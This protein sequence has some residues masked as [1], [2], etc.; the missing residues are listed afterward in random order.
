VSSLNFFV[1]TEHKEDNKAVGDIHIVK[2]FPSQKQAREHLS[3]LIERNEKLGHTYDHVTGDIYRVTTPKRVYTIKIVDWQYMF[4]KRVFVTSSMF[5]RIGYNTKLA[6]L[7]LR[8][9]T[10]NSL[11]SYDCPPAMFKALLTANS[12]GQ[13][14]NAAIKGK[15]DGRQ[16]E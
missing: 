1:V 11:W 5:T 15:Y 13:I 6:K 16:E 12:L 7:Y 3:S 14:Y 4:N 8:F 10:N 2:A 9:K